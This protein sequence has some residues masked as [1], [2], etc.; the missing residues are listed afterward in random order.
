MKAKRI[1]KP[2]ENPI[3]LSKS[4]VRFTPTGSIEP[5]AQRGRAHPGVEGRLAGEARMTKNPRMLGR[6]ILTATNCS[7]LSKE[8]STSFWTR[9]LANALFRCN[10]AKPLLCHAECGTV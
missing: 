8:Q 7:I 10:P 1:A 3:S 9:K 5:V 4:P 6:C 2:L